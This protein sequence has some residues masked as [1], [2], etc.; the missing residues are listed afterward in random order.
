[1]QKTLAISS[2]EMGITFGTCF[3]VPNTKTFGGRFFAISVCW[4]EVRHAMI[5]P[6][7]SAIT[8]LMLL[9]NN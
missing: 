5:E 7:N 6:N 8:L 1:M 4:M 3:D 2:I 9:Y